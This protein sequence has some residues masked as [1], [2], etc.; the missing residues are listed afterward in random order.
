MAPQ[1]NLTQLRQQK[2]LIHTQKCQTGPYSVQGEPLGGDGVGSKYCYRG[3][4]HRQVQEPQNPRGNQ[5]MSRHQLS[6]CYRLIYAPPQNACV[7]AQCDAVW[8]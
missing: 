5:A 4:E 7:E 2:T 3:R 8:R 1:A 6:S